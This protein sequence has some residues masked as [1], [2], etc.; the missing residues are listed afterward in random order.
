M[1]ATLPQNAKGYELVG[2]LLCEQRPQ[3][4]E[5]ILQQLNGET[6]LN[7]LRKYLDS[8]CK[9]QA[10]NKDSIL[11]SPFDRNALEQKRLFIGAILVIYRPHTRRLCTSLANLLKAKQQAL[12]RMIEE[13]KARYTHNIEDFKTK[14]DI[15]VE[16]MKEV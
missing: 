10:I 3:V 11:Y 7:K 16:K 13:A 6:D 2:R 9:L 15:T 12:S 14:V 4:V 1:L 8:F 5:E